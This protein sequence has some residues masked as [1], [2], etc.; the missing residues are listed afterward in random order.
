[1]KKLFALLSICLLLLTGCGTVGD[2]ESAADTATADAEDSVVVYNMVMPDDYELPVP[3]LTLDEKNKIFT[4]PYDLL[5]S[6]LPYGT[7]EIEND[8]LTAT[9]EDGEYTYLFKIKDE[10]T[11]EF[12]EDGSSEI[13]F[14]DNNTDVEIYDGA[15]FRK[16][17]ETSAD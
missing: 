3:T 5:S 15:Q 13:K 6:Y 17:E 1:M 2:T 11:L 16:A 14:I 12:I 10:N 9:T 8:L 4:F 7:Y